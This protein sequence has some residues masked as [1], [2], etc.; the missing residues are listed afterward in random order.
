[1]DLKARC[2]KSFDC[3]DDSDEYNCGPLVIDEKSYRKILPPI[4]NGKK[5]SVSVEMDVR[6]IK[7]IHELKME[8]NAE[9]S[10]LLKWK[11]PRIT[12]KNLA[13]NDNFLNRYWR[14]QIW[15]PDLT[16]ANTD[17]NLPLSSDKDGDDSIVVE[18]MREG[19]A[20][21][22]GPLELNEENTFSGNE[23]SLTLWGK[24]HNDFYCEFDLSNFPFDTQKCSIDIRVP[25]EIRNYITLSTSADVNVKL[26]CII[27]PS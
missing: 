17:G 26:L 24:H 2:N 22:N 20:N 21:L 1:M 16:F 3:G 12:F 6:S 15:L 14:G 27:F 23:N 4:N 18:V 13:E 10:I 19:S 5:T 7:S 9:V 11:D 8:F 25:W